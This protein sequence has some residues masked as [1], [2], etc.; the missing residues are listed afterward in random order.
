MSDE[1]EVTRVVSSMG[2]RTDA[3]DWQ[4][5][6]E[7]FADQVDVDYSSLNQGDAVSVT[8]AELVSGWQENLERLHAT[9]HLI[10]SHVVNVDG[11]SATCACNVIGTHVRPN[12]AGG[13]LWTVGGRYDIRLRRVEQR[14]RISALT[15]TV[16][17]ATGNQAILNA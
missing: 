4:G 12:A 6:E 17:W 2:L 13:H 7:L 9:Q 3:R 16:S 5:V 1:L 14:W 11:D 15:L 8:P 10:G